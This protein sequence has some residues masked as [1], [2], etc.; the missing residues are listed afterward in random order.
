MTL[1]EMETR[2]L[3]RLDE[4]AA[5][6]QGSAT[7]AYYSQT[8]VWRVL[9]EAQRLFCLLTLCLEKTGTLA[10]DANAFYHLLLTFSDFLVPLRVKVA[11]GARLAPDRLQ[12]L[13]ARSSSWQNTSGTPSRYDVL[14]LD[15]LAITPQPAAGGTSLTV[16][17]A[18]APMEM[19]LGSSVAEIPTEY[20]PSLIDYAIP[21]LRMKEGGAEFLT[22]LKYAQR[23]FESA[24]KMAE[25]V[26][27]RNRAA[28]YDREPFELTKP[29]ISKLVAAMTFSERKAANG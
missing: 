20:H 3:K 2:L 13:D 1:S 21:R 18:H 15:L 12:S 24:Q 4:D 7:H 22:S 6:P 27:Q 28:G 23:F 17:F 8:E 26:R 9:N 14:G 11:G 19:T 5:A 10:L 16:T 29:D 25:F